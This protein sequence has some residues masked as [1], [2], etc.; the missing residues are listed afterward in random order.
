MVGRDLELYMKG[1]CTNDSTISTDATICLIPGLSS[2]TPDGT[3]DGV[4][5][6]DS[7]LISRRE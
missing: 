4:N 5:L 1:R 2:V 3:V 6:T 7:C